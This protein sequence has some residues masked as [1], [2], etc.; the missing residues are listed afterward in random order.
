MENGGNQFAQ[1]G[2]L[3]F[4]PKNCKI[5]VKICK[6]VVKTVKALVSEVGRKRGRVAPEASEGHVLGTN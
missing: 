2:G 6:M 1:R 4:R 3:R 5:K